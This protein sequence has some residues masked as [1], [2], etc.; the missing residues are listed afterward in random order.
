MHVLVVG[1]R[2][3]G[4][5]VVD[6]LVDRGTPC[7]TYEVEHAGLPALFARHLPGLTAFARRAVTAPAPA[8]PSS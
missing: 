8:A 4:A 7:L 3:T 1:L 2:A 6:W 5:A